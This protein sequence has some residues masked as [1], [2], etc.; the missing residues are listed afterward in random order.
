MNRTTSAVQIF[1]RDSP[2]PG[3]VKVSLFL[4]STK[5]RLTAVF[6]LFTF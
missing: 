3:R 6:P 5:L 1:D 2:E 4:L